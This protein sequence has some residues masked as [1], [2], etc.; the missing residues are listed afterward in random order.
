LPWGVNNRSKILDLNNKETRATC[1]PCFFIVTYLRRDN[2]LII[3]GIFFDFF[4]TLVVP[5][6][7]NLGWSEWY[8]SVFPLYKK[9][10]IDI[11]YNDFNTICKNFWSYKYEDN[12]SGYTLFEKRLLSQIEFYGITASPEQIKDLAY[13]ISEAWFEK[14][15]LDH[16][17]FDML[18]YFKKKLK[19][20]LVT[21][22]DHPPFI[23]IMLERYKINQFFDSVIISGEAGVKKPMPEI[24]DP[25][26]AETGLS[27]S[28][29]VYVGDSI[30]DF[31]AAL[32]AGIVPII[33]RREG[34][35]NSSAPGSAEKG[36]VKTD[37]FLHE[38]FLNGQIDIISK[39]SG[40]KNAV[41]KFS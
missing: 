11:L 8:T 25:A 36:F 21:N 14:H 20:A 3:K 4:G 17:A 29:V 34:Q 31:R 38:L 9:N 19:I 1:Y 40:L 15:F 27:N 41:K 39:L 16:E 26:L 24:F 10:R 12:L 30:M 35:H 22:F 7:L 18:E 2:Y 37:A 5:A 32:G 6:N 33:I 23:R 28:E 13:D